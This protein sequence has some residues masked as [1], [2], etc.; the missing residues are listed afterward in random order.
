MTNFISVPVLSILFI[1]LLSSCSNQENSDEVGEDEQQT[2][3]HVHVD[4]LI[5]NHIILREEIRNFSPNLKLM[6]TVYFNVFAPFMIR[7]DSI[8]YSISH[9]S[10]LQELDSFKLTLN[11]RLYKEYGEVIHMDFRELNQI[12]EKA[13]G[14][15]KAWHQHKI[16]S[17]WNRIDSIDQMSVNTFA[18][19]YQLDSS[20]LSKFKPLQPIE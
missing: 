11:D 4:Q 13:E 10:L 17:I 8:M 14:N 5:Q 9:D 15:I 20:T 3:S 6:D 18:K 1:S 16:D 2:Q 12:Y 19:Y 7:T